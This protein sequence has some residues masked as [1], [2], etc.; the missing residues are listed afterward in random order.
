[1]IA[2]S[3]INILLLFIIILEH[4]LDK[5]KTRKYDY[6]LCYNI[7]QGDHSNTEFTVLLSLSYVSENTL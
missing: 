4:R 3:E 6:N 1:M 2:Q 5:M 7:S